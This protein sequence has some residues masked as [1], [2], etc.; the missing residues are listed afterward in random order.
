VIVLVAASREDLNV[1]WLARALTITSTVML[2]VGHPTPPTGPVV[3]GSWQ[4]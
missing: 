4:G 1:G 3:R 2:T